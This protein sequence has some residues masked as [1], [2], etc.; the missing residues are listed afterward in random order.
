[1][2]S[3]YSVNDIH[4]HLWQLANF[5]MIFISPLSTHWIVKALKANLYIQMRS[6]KPCNSLFHGKWNV[7]P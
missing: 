6:K 3:N 1:M 7:S 2:V 5:F 4:E